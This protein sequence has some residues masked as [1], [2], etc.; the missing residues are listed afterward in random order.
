MFLNTSLQ[1]EKA[2]RRADVNLAEIGVIINEHNSL[3]RPAL[4]I[5]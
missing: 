5:K 1:P 4:Q 3:A 2:V